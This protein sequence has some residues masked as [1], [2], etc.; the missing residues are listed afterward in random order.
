MSYAGLTSK[1]ISGTAIKQSPSTRPI[2]VPGDLSTTLDVDVAT[3]G[4]LGVVQIGSGI[5]ISPSGIIS[6]TGSSISG[7]WTPM[8]MSWG[9][10]TILLNT[11][12]GKYSKVGQL[13]TCTF[14]VEVTNISW[15]EDKDV[16]KLT[17][18]PFT[19]VAGTGYVGSMYF[20]YFQNMGDNIDYISGSVVP[21]S[22]TLD[23]WYT[24][25]QAKS[26]TRLN[27]A[28]LKVGSRLVGSIEYFSA[29]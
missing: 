22:T 3:T 20:S 18:L 13:V 12:S 29:I 2:S 21:S 11:K 16:L 4:S 8:I 15:G 9:T 28:S 14:D 25:Q 10:G 1:V 5:N 17:N 27:Q 19:S 24:N 6:A 7:N 23:L 26:M